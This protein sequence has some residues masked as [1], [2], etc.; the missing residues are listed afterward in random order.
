[1]RFSLIVA[2]SLITATAQADTPWVL[3]MDIRFKNPLAARM[4]GWKLMDS[5]ELKAEC[6]KWAA[7]MRAKSIAELA[8]T[9]SA[10]YQCF[11]A[12]TIPRKS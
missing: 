2:F 6:E 4:E 8:A 5:F 9:K 12:G 7:E 3:R 10:H 11:P 1:M